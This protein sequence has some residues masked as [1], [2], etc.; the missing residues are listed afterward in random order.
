MSAD[1]EQAVSCHLG[2]MF[3]VDNNFNVFLN[4]MV[5]QWKWAGTMIRVEQQFSDHALR[6]HRPLK[7]LCC[8]MQ[9]W[10]WNQVWRQRLY[11]WFPVSQWKY[12]SLWK[13]VATQGRCERSGYSKRDTND[14]QKYQQS[15]TYKNPQMPLE[16]EPLSKASSKCT[17]SSS[18]PWKRGQTIK[19][20]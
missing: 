15:F 7:D 1:F 20:H 6:S 11:L 12:A 2:K 13:R 5:Y 3:S 14:H 17:T 4:V 8:K 19:D 18:S 16:E 10:F 9:L